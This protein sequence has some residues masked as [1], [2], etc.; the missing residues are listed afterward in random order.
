MNLHR[1]AL[2]VSC[3]GLL[4]SAA[5]G[6]FGAAPKPSPTPTRLPKQARTATAAAAAISSP[7]APTSVPSSAT[8]LAATAPVAETSPT[9]A[10]QSGFC[11]D[12]QAAA[13]VDKFKT[14]VLTSNGSL[15][16]TLVSPAHGMDARLFRSGR[17]VNYD[18]DH[19]KFLFVSTFVVD[20]GL[21]PA[22]GLP[23]KGSFHDLILPAL[24]DVFNRAYTLTCN[25]IKVGGTTYQASWP[26]SGIDF[27]S[28]YHPGTAANGNLDWHTWLLGIDYEGG[29][30]Y[31]YAIM[32]FQWEP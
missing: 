4:T 23:T 16:A 6:S 9:A 8:P 14:A 32:Q 21:A 3:F 10:P 27:Y 13:L 29:K 20:W 11:S 12:G 18:P 19:A 1:L 5:C 7:I 28:A 25:Q 30:P 26:Y 31:L 17:V 15:L 22:S 2:L 24:A